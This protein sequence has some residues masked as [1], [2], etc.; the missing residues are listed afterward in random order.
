MINKIFTKK[1]QYCG[2][3]IQSLYET[4]LNSNL[5]IHEINCSHKPKKGVK[6]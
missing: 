3:E 4:Q 5:E 2:R 1:C 6:V